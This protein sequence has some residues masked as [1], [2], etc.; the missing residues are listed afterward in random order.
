MH[1]LSRPQRRELR[2]REGDDRRTFRDGGR[3]DGELRD[4]HERGLRAHPEA[5][6]PHRD[7]GRNLHVHRDADSD[8]RLP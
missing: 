7:P 3:L 8:A 6:K 4:E 5:E 1:P 2:Q